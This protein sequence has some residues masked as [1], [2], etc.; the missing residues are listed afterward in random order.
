MDIVQELKAVDSNKNDF[1]SIMKRMEKEKEEMHKKLHLIRVL[2]LAEAIDEKIKN[3]Y[4]KEKNIVS[5]ELNRGVYGVISYG[6]YEKDGDYSDDQDLDG[7][8]QILTNVSEFKTKYVNSSFES[9]SHNGYKIRL[10]KGFREKLL[11]AL[12]SEPLKKTL[13][14][15]QLYSEMDDT[16]NN[17]V[18]KVKM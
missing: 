15:S 7:L 13:E 2:A 10:N 3:G 18:K 9:G 16:N 8:G 14:Y 4:L 11:N 1:H 5:L 12:L 6:F 17:Y